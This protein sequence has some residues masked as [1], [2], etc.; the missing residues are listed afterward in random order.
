M[1]DDTVTATLAEW[2]ALTEGATE[3]PWVPSVRHPSVEGRRAVGI[4]HDWDH[5]AF[6]DAD[7]EFIA[8]APDI[9]RALL[10]FV[11]DVLAACEKAKAN[12][13]EDGSVK[14]HTAII[15]QALTK[16]IGGA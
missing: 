11:E 2:E 4:A 13:A 9:A 16:R 5:G 12:P 7:A 1:T 10:G 15:E 8:A 6:L 3:G 14:V